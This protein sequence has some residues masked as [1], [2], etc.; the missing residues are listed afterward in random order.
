[1]GRVSRRLNGRR[2]KLHTQPSVATEEFGAQTAVE[3]LDLARRRRTARLGQQMLDTVFAA[4][5]IEEHFHRRM[6]ERASAINE[7][8]PSSIR[9][10]HIDFESGGRGSNPRPTDYQW[11]ARGDAGHC[12]SY[13]V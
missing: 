5:R 1:M 6:V 4:G 10:A 13:L 11:G 12:L 9:R 3:S 7:A 2:R 8:E